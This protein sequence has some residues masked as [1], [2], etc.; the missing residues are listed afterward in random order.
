MAEMRKQ[1]GRLLA[2]LLAA[3]VWA[4]FCVLNAVACP[5]VPLRV[6]LYVFLFLAVLYAILTVLFSAVEW[7]CSPSAHVMKL[8]A[9]R[10][11]G[12]EHIPDDEAVASLSADA[13]VPVEFAKGFLESLVRHYSNGGRWKI[14][15]GAIRCTDTFV[16]D[17]AV[18]LHELPRR[19]ATRARGRP[20][21]ETKC[22]SLDCGLYY[23]F[24]AWV[25]LSDRSHKCRDADG[26]RRLAEELRGIA[27]RPDLSVSALCSKLHLLSR[28]LA[29]E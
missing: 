4:L 1:T 19:F 15:V 13:G 9:S 21:E 3:L 14:A 10:M 24:L 23:D 2:A 27:S 25:W 11:A 22:M 6:Y 17:F 5:G 28:S 7:L 12:R 20:W 16:E 8:I 29:A 26:Y 18:R